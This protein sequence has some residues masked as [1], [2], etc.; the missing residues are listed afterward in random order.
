MKKIVLSVL[1]VVLAVSL[2]AGAAAAAPQ[3]P[4]GAGWMR[5]YVLRALA[6]R[7]NL[8]VDELNSRLASGE[9]LYQ[10][11]LAEGVKA[12]DIPSLMQEVRKEAI[13]AALADGVITQAQAD[14]M[15]ANLNQRGFGFGMGKRSMGDGLLRNYMIAALAKE[16][17]LSPEEVQARL[18][19]GETLV[20]IALAKGVPAA[21]LPNLMVR[22]RKAAIQ[23]ALQDGV[24]TQAQADRMLNRLEQRGKGRFF[25]RPDRWPGR[26]AHGEGCPRGWRQP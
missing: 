17:N 24:I 3:T 23:A 8:T 5:D 22:V 16:L 12:A 25:D 21:E 10:I 11:L 19:A 6:Q 2:F 7:L 18:A 9:T 26:G 1:L 15:L 13:Q 14:W 4:H 20:Q